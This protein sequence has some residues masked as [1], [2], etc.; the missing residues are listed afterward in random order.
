MLAS[1]KLRSKFFAE[2]GIEMV[3]VEKNLIDE[4][5]SSHSKPSMPKQPVFVLEEKYTGKSVQDKFTLIKSKLDE[6]ADVLLTATLDEIAWF[7]NLRSTDIEYNPVFFS[8][9][10]FFVGKG[11]EHNRAQLYINKEKVEDPEVQKHL[12]ENHITVFPYEQITAD[13]AK[14]VEEKKKVTID[15]NQ[16]NYKLY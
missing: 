8:Y 2:K 10:L 14:L 7:L 16:L 13:L 3:A 9:L 5:W 12:H 4:V 6:K 11:E 15:E 1:Y